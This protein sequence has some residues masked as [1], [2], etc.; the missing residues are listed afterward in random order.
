MIDQNSRFKSLLSD[1]CN[2][3]ELFIDYRRFEDIDWIT[4]SLR[5]HAKSQDIPNIDPCEQYEIRIATGP[6]EITQNSQELFHLGPYYETDQLDLE[7]VKLKD[8]KKYLEEHPFDYD[9]SMNDDSVTVD[10]GQACAIRMEV[11]LKNFDNENEKNYTNV[12]NV[13]SKTKVKYA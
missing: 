11:H 2:S 6:S 9:V 3:N 13:T 5:K 7:R 10:F 8:S 12:G 4:V 1:S